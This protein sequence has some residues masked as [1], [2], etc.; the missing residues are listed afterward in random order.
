MYHLVEKG[1]KPN[2]MH[3]DF[4]MI[5]KFLNLAIKKGLTKNY[6]FK[7]FEIPSE[8]SLKEYLTLKEVGDLHNLYESGIL[9]KKLQN[10]LFYFLIACYTGLRFSD[11]SR[12]SA[13]Y[14]K[15]SG[16]QY[17]ISMLMKKTRK[18]VE[19]PLSNRVVKLLMKRVGVDYTPSSLQEIDL[20]GN[21]GLFSRKLKQSNSRVNNDIREIIAL[22][23]IN[24]YISFHCSRHS[25]AINS[26][27]LG[28]SL[29]V[30][31]NILG[32]TQ[33]KT[34]QIYAKIVNELKVKQME[35]WNYD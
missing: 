34:T 25:F 24:K 20:L 8:D 32:H 33:L 12:L 29:E 9:S 27:V 15:Q 5:R 10:T 23:K 31:S 18:P 7:D 11:V 14:L 2:T 19:V 30:I 3:G 28:I 21:E 26:L 17:F 35:K 22:Q 1:N 16:K 4:K 13:L 6:P